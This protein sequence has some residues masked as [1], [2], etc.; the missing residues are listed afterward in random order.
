MMVGDNDIDTFFISSGNRLEGSYPAVH[1]DNQRCPRILCLPYAMGMEP[2]AVAESFG[3]EVNAVG[4]QFPKRIIYDRR[5]GNAVGI[6]V[7]VDEYAFMSSYGLSDPFHC[8][9]NTADIKRV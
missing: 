9:R 1:S 6:I 5:C 4:P 8:C 2:V 3:D 7:A